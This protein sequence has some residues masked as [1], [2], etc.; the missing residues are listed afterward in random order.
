MSSIND[1][2]RFVVVAGLPSARIDDERNPIAVAA[3]REQVVSGQAQPDEAAF[4]RAKSDGFER[5]REAAL[6]KGAQSEVAAQYGR[7]F[8]GAGWLAGR[9]SARLARADV[10]DEERAEPDAEKD[11][12][13][14]V[15]ASAAQDG[16]MD[17]S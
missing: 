8:G 5:R 10:H 3:R 2:T 14:R 12:S 9:T 15:S 17:W 16:V 7:A 13:K 6:A 11:E 1:K 4:D